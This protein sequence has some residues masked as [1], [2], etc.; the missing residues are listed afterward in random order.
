MNPANSTQQNMMLANNLAAKNPYLVSNPFPSLDMPN[1]QGSN[2]NNAFRE[3]RQVNKS[4]FQVP[5]TQQ[6]VHAPG[7]NP[8][9]FYNQH[10]HFRNNGGGSL[11]NQNGEP[12]I[13]NPMLSTNQLAKKNFENLSQQNKQKRLAEEALRGFENPNAR[14]QASNNRYEGYNEAAMSNYNN[15]L[16]KPMYSPNR[17]S[18][19]NPPPNQHL[20]ENGLGYV[21]GSIHYQPNGANKSGVTSFYSRASPEGMKTGFSSS[22]YKPYSL[23][24]YRVVK[25]KAGVQLG[26]LGPNTNTE[27]QKVKEKR[28][29]MLEFA[30]NVKLFNDQR[31]PGPENSLKP[32]REKEKSPSKRDVG[33]EFARHVPKPRQR[34]EASPELKSPELK[35]R[36]AES[37]VTYKRADSDVVTY[38]PALM[39]N[40]V[41][42]DLAEYERRHNQYKA[43]LEKLKIA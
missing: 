25:D 22:S 6:S 9:S 40:D 35:A 30:Q 21:P 26:G 17:E 13:F 39:H 7:F 31:G 15:F 29:K 8:E 24:D 28:D 33:L 23:K 42:N 16:D 38:R 2:E 12:Q 14:L 36:K 37:D 43:Q 27:W 5:M 18:Y 1:Y 34:R 10:S 19:S 3:S 11:S 20:E 41:H 32:K 4:P